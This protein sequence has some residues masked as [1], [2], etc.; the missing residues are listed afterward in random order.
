[1][2]ALQVFAERHLGSTTLPRDR[3]TFTTSTISLKPD[4]ISQPHAFFLS[5]FFIG[6]GCLPV[7]PW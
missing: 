1:M 3:N 2:G 5:S 4:Q 6:F 7:L